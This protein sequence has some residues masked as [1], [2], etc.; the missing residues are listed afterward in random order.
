MI[1]SDLIRETTDSAA[2]RKL[3]GSAEWSSKRVNF[4]VLVASSTYLS[5][6]SSA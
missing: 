2:N 1:K 5:S 4:L 3:K 6:S